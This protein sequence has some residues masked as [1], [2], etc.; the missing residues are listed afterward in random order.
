MCGI[1]GAVAQRDVTPILLEGLRRLEYRGYDSAGILVLDKSRASFNRIRVQGKVNDLAQA[2]DAGSLN[3][4]AGLA[5]TRWATHGR[6]SVNNAH[7]LICR[8]E[9]GLVH[10]GIIEN[11]EALRKAQV[12]AGYDFESETDTEV[13]VNQ[14]H[15]HLQATGDLFSA[16]AQT[17][18]EL[19]GTYALG[20]IDRRHPERLVAA[21]KGS[22]LVIGVGIREHFIASDVFALLPVTRRFMVLEEG[23]L[24]EICRDRVLIFDQHG[25]Q[26][27]RPVLTSELSSDSADKAGYRHYMAKEIFN[28]PT[29]I[30]DT[31]EGRVDHGAII[32]SEFGMAASTLFPR[33]ENVHIIACGSSYHAGLVARYWLEAEGIQCSVDIASEYRYRNTVVPANTL[34]LTISQSGETLDV[35]E[36][37]RLA[38]TRPY[39]ARLAICNVP[40]S[41]LTRAADMVFFTRAGIEIG[42]ASTKTFTTQLVALYLL[43]LALARGRHADKAQQSRLINLLERLPGQVNQVLEL[44]RQLEQ[45]AEEFIHKRHTL[46]L[47]R[48]AMLPVAMEGALKLKEISY[49]HAEAYAAGELKHGP[50]ALIDDGMPVIAVAPNNSLLGKLNSNLQEARARGARLYVFSDV[51]DVIRQSATT[52]VLQLPAVDNSIAPIVYTVPLQLLS[53]HVAVLKG[54]DVDQPRNLAKSVTVE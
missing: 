28:Q 44:D 16:V 20:V 1:V 27:Q 48:G 42:V 54:A 13:A 37:V 49:I 10:N 45:L 4:S 18:P 22:P 46:F 11:H 38:A 33:V 43:A 19:E 25:K 34:F 23:D 30:A 2:S 31:L 51:H 47:G 21:R 50:L 3:G 41:S 6:P 15:Y 35:L 26:V 14:I 29:A 32:E 53:Y 24:A 17:L 36:A 39:L 40:E 8:D 9:I 52:K 7:P 12:A 5:H